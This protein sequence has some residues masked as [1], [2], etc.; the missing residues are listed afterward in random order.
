MAEALHCAGQTGLTEYAGSG[1]CCWGL[2]LKVRSGINIKKN[3]YNIKHY[4]YQYSVNG[5]EELTTGILLC[6][7]KLYSGFLI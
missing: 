4:R 7:W 2:G 3:K 5:K 6:F 1:L